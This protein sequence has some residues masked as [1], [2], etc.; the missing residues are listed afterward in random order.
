MLGK[1]KEQQ[2]RV[3]L[4]EILMSAQNHPLFSGWQDEITI[5]KVIEAG[6]DT[7]FVT[8][9]VAWKAKE[10][11]ELLTPEHPEGL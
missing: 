3:V 11:L 6:G 8:C 7:C 2:I 4:Q 10:A 9:D 5:E 1:A